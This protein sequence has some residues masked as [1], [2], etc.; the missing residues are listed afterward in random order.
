MVINNRWKCF[1]VVAES[2]VASS[3]EASYGT[4]PE[5]QGHPMEPGVQKHPIPSCSG[6]DATALLQY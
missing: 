1:P 2:H 3:R 6:L 4:E 5:V